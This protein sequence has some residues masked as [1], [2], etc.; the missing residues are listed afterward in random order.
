MSELRLGEYR[1]SMATNPLLRKASLGKPM[2]RGFDLPGKD[3]IY[4][5]PNHCM[6]G[7]AQEAMQYCVLSEKRNREKIIKNSDK[8]NKINYIKKNKIAVEKG[9]VNAREQANG[10]KELEKAYLIEPPTKTKSDSNLNGC[11]K[12]LRNDMTF[13]ISTRPSTPVFE[14]LEHRYQM[15]WLQ[16]RHKN[17]RQMEE[18]Q[19]KA[20]GRSGIKNTQANYQKQA[21]IT[22]NLKDNDTKQY[23]KDWQMNKWK[24]IGSNLNT[25]RSD[26][27]KQDSMNYHYETMNTRQG[28]FGHGNY[29][30]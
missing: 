25:F 29:I 5:R 21:K 10:I 24:K 20:K 23:K 16:R 8:I 17:Q 30:D 18:C 14:L 7:G 12:N 27:L 11:N 19:K 4:G 3:F 13:G 2:Q 26:K 9:L 15:T 28:I 22:Q 6:D 1:P